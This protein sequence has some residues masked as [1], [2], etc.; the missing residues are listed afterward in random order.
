MD[1]RLT[2]GEK[3]KQRILEVSAYLF[4]TQGFHGTTT[5]QITDRLKMTPASLYTHFKGKDELFEAVLEA[6]HPWFQIPESVRLAEGDTIEEFVKDAAHRLLAA[7]DKRPEMVK[8]HLIELIEF[9][10]QHLPQLFGSNFEK[11]TGVLREL[12]AERDDFSNLS[13]PTLS[14]ALLGLFFAYLVGDRFIGTGLNLGLDQSAFDYF[15]DNYLFGVVSSKDI[16]DQTS[17]T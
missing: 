10:G 15:T 8:L 14:R 16:Q 12:V 6:Y 11:M 2:K 3:T 5:R 17:D 9:N 7:W 1:K 4:V 13:I